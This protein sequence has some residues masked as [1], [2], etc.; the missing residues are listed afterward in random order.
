MQAVEMSYLRSACDVSKMNGMS[1]ESAYERLEVW[2]G[3]G[4]ETTDV[5]VVWPHGANGRE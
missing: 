2:S 4:S 3:G 5:K 1:N